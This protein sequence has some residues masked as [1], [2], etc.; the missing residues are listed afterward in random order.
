MGDARTLVGQALQHLINL[1]RLSLD[2]EALARNIFE[3]AFEQA[4]HGEE[5]IYV[6]SD[7]R[8][9]EH[10]LMRTAKDE[11]A[12]KHRHKRREKKSHGQYNQESTCALNA[13]LNEPNRMDLIR[14]I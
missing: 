9:T 12:L 5:G 14:S 1:Q 6:R 10:R 4:F 2:M 7:M 8:E 3:Q 11:R 13:R